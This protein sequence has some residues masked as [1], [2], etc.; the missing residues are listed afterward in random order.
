MNESAG[1]NL[2]TEADTRKAYEDIWRQKI[3][4]GE[5]EII[6]FQKIDGYLRDVYGTRFYTSEFTASEKTED[7]NVNKVKGT[8]TFQEADKGWKPIDLRY[9]RQYK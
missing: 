9:K 1:G 5:L 4:S 8:V 6:S 3:K 2:P 7:G